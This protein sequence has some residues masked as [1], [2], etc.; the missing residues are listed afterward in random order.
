LVL[1]CLLCPLFP[2]LLARLVVL[3]R[4]WDPCFRF[5]RC[6][7]EIR[8][9]LENLLVQLILENPFGLFRRLRLCLPLCLGDLDFQCCR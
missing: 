3:G 5:D 2:C 4:R 1:L 6:L 8:L 7:L 9:I